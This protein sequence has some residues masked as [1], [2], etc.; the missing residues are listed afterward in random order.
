VASV[1]DVEFRAPPADYPGRV[2]CGRCSGHYPPYY[3]SCHRSYECTAGGRNPLA[4]DPRPVASPHFPG[5]V[6]AALTPRQREAAELSNRGL[7]HRQAAGRLRISPKNVGKLLAKAR[8]KL[9]EM[10]GGSAPSR[11]VRSAASCG[12]GH[13]AGN[14]EAHPV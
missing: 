5:Q 2:S 9:E 12:N 11:P 14:G 13:A 4:A 6:L 7:S 8:A 1:A 3:G 10:Q